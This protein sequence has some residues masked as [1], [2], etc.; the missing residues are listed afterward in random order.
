MEIKN[1]LKKLKEISS[2]NLLIGLTGGI[3]CGKSTVL[4]FF[5]EMGAYTVSSDEK[6][7]EILTNKKNCDKIL[8]RYPQVSNPDGFINRKKLAKLIFKNKKARQVIE[9]VIHPLVVDGIISELCRLEGK[10]IVMEVPLLFETWLKDAVEISIS[11]YSDLDKKILRLRK[12]G[13]D[14]RDIKLRMKSQIED[15]IKVNVADVVISNN[16]SIKELKNKTKEIYESFYKL[17]NRR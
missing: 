3:G 14:L 10:I 12:R 15:K 13:M 2:K 5:K 6:V 7:K 16:G 4:R 17:L 9:C 8:I 11:V 1:Q